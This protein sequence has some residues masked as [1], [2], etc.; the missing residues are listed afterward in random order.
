MASTQEVWQQFVDGVRRFVGKRVSADDVEDVVQNIFLEYIVTWEICVKKNVPKHGY[1]RLRAKR[2]LTITGSARDSFLTTH[3]N[4]Q[5][6]PMKR[7]RHRKISPATRVN[8]TCMK[9]S[10]RGYARWP[11]KLRSRTGAP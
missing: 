7:P 10:S 2:S 1:S 3:L 5:S 11:M 6:F 4:E 8:M 9:K